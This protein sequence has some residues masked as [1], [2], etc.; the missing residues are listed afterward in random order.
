MIFNVECTGNVDD[1][2]GTRTIERTRTRVHTETARKVKKPAM[3]VVVVHN[4]PFTPRSFV[5]EVLRSYFNKTE[6]EAT[7]IMLL[8]H[9]FGVGVV[10]MFTFEIAEAKASQVNEYAKLNGHPLQFSVQDA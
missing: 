10:A 8:A 2:N 5:V 3:Y 7:R 4:D 6:A 1:A 9:N